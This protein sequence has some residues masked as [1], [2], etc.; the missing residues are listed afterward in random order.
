MVL[1]MVLHQIHHEIKLGRTLVVGS[2]LDGICRDQWVSGKGGG[3]KDYKERSKGR[4]VG[5][6]L[7]NPRMKGSPWMK[8]WYNDH[9]DLEP[10]LS[11]QMV[12]SI[13]WD[14]WSTPNYSRGTPG[15]HP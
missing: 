11:D 1:G 6:P 9:K 2:C 15:R 14:G 10:S 3:N 5:D 12:P 8:A 13:A 7:R 4:K